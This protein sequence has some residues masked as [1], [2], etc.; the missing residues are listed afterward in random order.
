MTRLHGMLHRVYLYML[1]MSGV[2]YF[3]ACFPLVDYDPNFK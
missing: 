3:I 1:T 2:A